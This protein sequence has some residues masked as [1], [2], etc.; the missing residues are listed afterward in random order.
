[1][2]IDD[3]RFVDASHRSLPE[4]WVIVEVSFEVVMAL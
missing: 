2:M 1:M 4:G 3:I